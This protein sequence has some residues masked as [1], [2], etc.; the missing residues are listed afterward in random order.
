MNQSSVQKFKSQ[1]PL[2]NNGSLKND[3]VYLDNAATT[4]K[5]QCVIDTASSY[6]LTCNANVHRASHQLSAEATSRFEKARTAVKHFINAHSEKEIIWTK[7]TT[8]SINL[9]AQSWGMSH[10]K[11]GD[12]IL[13]TFSEHH[14]N[15]VPWQ[16]VSNRTGACIKVLPLD[17]YGRINVDELDNYI[18]ENTALVA[19]SMISNVIGKVND[20]KQ[21]ITKAHQVNAK[22]LIDAAQAV[23][24]QSLDVQ[25]LNCD[26]LVFSAHKMYGPSGIGV[27]YGKTECLNAMTP[28]QFGGEMIKKVSFEHT[29]YNELPFKF[30]AGTPNIA[31]VF[32]LHAAI[33]FVELHRQYMDAQEQMLVNYCYEQLK[34]I[35]PLTFIFEGSPDI[36]I[37]SF[38]IKGHHNQD[39][40]SYLDSQ[41]IAI[42]AGHHCAMPLMEYR[43]VLGC[44]R[45]SLA[46]YN[47][48]HEVEQLVKALGTLVENSELS[49]CNEKQKHSI[50]QRF[51]QAKGWDGRHRELMLL[52]KSFVRMPRERREKD[53]L[54]QGCESDVWLSSSVDENNI[55]HF[56]ADSDARVVRGLLAIVLAAYHGKQ[57]HDIL[58]FDIEDYFEQLGLS[59]HLSP[60]RGNGIRAIVEQILSKVKTHS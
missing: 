11:P 53:L 30:E 20:V 52:G 56:S 31:G 13:L 51:K 4:Q 16:E 58:S 38:T 15:I 39:V 50:V 34:K 18:N 5:P 54:I 57:A 26:F 49:E 45:V 3:I 37:F 41:H 9:V 24:H 14:A 2:F 27:L 43:S 17:K 36:P 35:Q 23:A 10:L 46:P 28:Y 29:S 55:W 1:F 44:L 7:G 21:L 48:K 42:R 59:Q 40:A 32:G 60:T 22:V 25:M 47:T 19:C 33:E 8:E 12:E 6:Y